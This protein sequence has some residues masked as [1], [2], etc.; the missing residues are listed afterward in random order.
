MQIICI[1]LL[2]FSL[3]IIQNA[4][5]MQINTK[6]YTIQSNQRFYTKVTTGVQDETFELQDE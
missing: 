2:W 3:F 1:E 6:G 4:N 5:I